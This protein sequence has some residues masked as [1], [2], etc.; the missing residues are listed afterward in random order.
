MQCL[1]LSLAHCHPM[2]HHLCVSGHNPENHFQ[3]N[4]PGSKYFGKITADRFRATETMRRKIL[5]QF[6]VN[7]SNQITSNISDTTFP[8]HEYNVVRHS[9]SLRQ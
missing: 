9:N 2:I 7:Y 3:N 6:L 8:E 4:Q 1:T 5:Q